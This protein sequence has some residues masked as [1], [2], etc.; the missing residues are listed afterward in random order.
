MGSDHRPFWPAMPRNS[1]QATISGPFVAT[2]RIQRRAQPDHIVGPEARRQ[3][4]HPHAKAINPLR[5]IGHLELWI[6]AFGPPTAVIHETGGLQIENA[7]S[8]IGSAH[9]TSAANSRAGCLPVAEMSAAHEP[10]FSYDQPSPA[11]GSLEHQPNR[12]MDLTFHRFYF[13]SYCTSYCIKNGV[14]LSNR[15]KSV[16]RIR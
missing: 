15:F 8:G 9:E 10:H 6:P 5:L 12:L 2:P 7:Q 1:S 14:G 3:L 16:L 13:P 11:P 4:A